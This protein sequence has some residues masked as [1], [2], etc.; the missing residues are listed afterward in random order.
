MIEIKNKVIAIV[1]SR[2]IIDY[3]LMNK[4][5]DDL[6]LA[7]NENTIITGCAK[8]A[9]EAARK[10][11]ESNNIKLIVK[12]ADWEKYDRA[13]GPIRNS[14]IIELADIV[15][16]FWNLKSLGTKDTIIKA[17]RKGIPVLL[18]YMNSKVSLKPF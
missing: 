9:D 18:Y 7:K 15:V 8:G 3:K 6:G 11:A 5:L 10:F 12:K 14:Q 4:T 1:G 17:N 16:C 2:T 13:A